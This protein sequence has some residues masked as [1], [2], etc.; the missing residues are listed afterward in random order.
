[1]MKVFM[2]C[3]LVLCSLALAEDITIYDP[4][5]VEPTEL[6]YVLGMVF[7]DGHLSQKSLKLVNGGFDGDASL[8]GDSEIACEELGMDKLNSE[9]SENVP[10]TLCRYSDG[11]ANENEQEYSVCTKK[12]DYTRDRSYYCEIQN[13][14]GK[15]VESCDFTFTIRTKCY[16]CMT[17]DSESKELCFSEDKFDFTL[18][19]PFHED[20]SKIVFFEKKDRSK[21]QVLS[22]GL[23]KFKN[24]VK[25]HAYDD[26]AL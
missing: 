25:K 24:A 17:D 13:A 11:A 4:D 8:G 10:G 2:A 12:R 16:E 23:G 14:S 3:V 6:H 21:K 5:A 26:A 19:I 7:N 18:S 9:Y 22:V 20:G 1:M 15:F